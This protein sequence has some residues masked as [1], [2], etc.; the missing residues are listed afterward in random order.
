[1]D[2]VEVLKNV[3]YDSKDNILYFLNKKINFTFLTDSNQQDY[4]NKQVIL[5]P[6]LNQENKLWINIQK[7]MAAI[8]SAKLFEFTINT[9]KRY[10]SKHVK[11]ESEFIVNVTELI[12][13]IFKFLNEGVFKIFQCKQLENCIKIV[14][15][16][17]TYNENERIFNM[18]HLQ[19][20]LLVRVIYSIYK[21]V[22][23]ISFFL[24]NSVCIS[25]THDLSYVCDDFK[26]QNIYIDV[27]CNSCK[28]KNMDAINCKTSIEKKEEISLSILNE[29]E[30]ISGISRDNFEWNLSSRVE[31]LKNCGFHIY[32]DCCLMTFEWNL[33][34][35]ELHHNIAAELSTH[36]MNI[37]VNVNGFSLPFGR[38]HSLF[39]RKIESLNDIWSIAPLPQFIAKYNNSLNIVQT[40]SVI[41]DRAM[42]S[43]SGLSNEQ[44]QLVYF[45]EKDNGL[46][47]Y[48]LV[49][50]I[51]NSKGLIETL[52][53]QRNYDEKIKTLYIINDTS[54]YGSGNLLH[55]QNIIKNCKF[56]FETFQFTLKTEIDNFL[57]TNNTDSNDACDDSPYET[58]NNSNFDD[59]EDESERDIH[60]TYDLKMPIMPYNKLEITNYYYCLKINNYI[61]KLSFNNNEKYKLKIIL[62]VLFDKTKYS[63]CFEKINKD[64]NRTFQDILSELKPFF[65]PQYSDINIDKF[66]IDE[67]GEGEEE[68]QEDGKINFNSNFISKSNEKNSLRVI[69]TNINQKPTT[70]EYAMDFDIW[71][72]NNGEI[73]FKWTDVI[74]NRAKNRLTSKPTDE[75]LRFFISVIDSI[76]NL[77]DNFICGTLLIDCLHCE[78]AQAKKHNKVVLFQHKFIEISKILICDSKKNFSLWCQSTFLKGKNGNYIIKYMSEKGKKKKNEQ[79]FNI[80]KLNIKNISQTQK[81]VQFHGSRHFTI[82]DYCIEF[83]LRNGF[84]STVLFMLINQ[85]RTKFSH[86]KHSSS[87]LDDLFT[88]LHFRYNLNEHAKYILLSYETMY[89]YANLLTMSKNYFNINGI[90]FALLWYLRDR[91]T[92]V[93]LQ[94]YCEKLKQV[95]SVF[96]VDIEFDKYIVS[97][98]CR[99]VYCPILLGD[100]T[101]LFDGTQYIKIDP[102]TYKYFNDAQ[103]FGTINPIKFTLFDYSRRTTRGIYSPVLNILEDNDVTLKSD[104]FQFINK[105]DIDCYKREVYDLCMDIFYKIPHFIEYTKKNIL[106]FCLHG[107]LT[108]L[109]KTTSESI[110]NFKFYAETSVNI[111]DLQ[112]AYN[113][114][115]NDY[116]LTN[117]KETIFRGINDRDTNDEWIRNMSV[118]IVILN[119]IDFYS[120]LQKENIDSILTILFGNQ[121]YG[122]INVKKENIA[123]EKRKNETD[124]HTDYLTLFENKDI[125]SIFH[126]DIAI[127][128]NTTNNITENGSLSILAKIDNYKNS[129]WNKIAEYNSQAKKEL[130]NQH[131]K[132][133]LETINA[134]VE[135]TS[136]LIELQFQNYKLRDGDAFHNKTF[137][138]VL[139]NILNNYT[140]DEIWEK[141]VANY[142]TNLFLNTLENYIFQYALLLTNFFAKRNV[143]KGKIS[144]FYNIFQHS[145]EHR[146]TIYDGS[147]NFIIKY[148]SEPFIANNNIELAAFLRS[149]CE[150]TEINEKIL[151][152]EEK[153][154][155]NFRYI[156]NSEENEDNNVRI[157]FK[158]NEDFFL[159]AIENND[160]IPR[161]V[162]QSRNR[163]CSTNSDGSAYT[164]YTDDDDDNC[165]NYDDN[166]DEDVD[167]SDLNAEC[168]E[169]YDEKNYKFVKSYFVK[170]VSD[171][172][173]KKNI[174]IEKYNENVM[175]DKIYISF[176]FFLY[177]SS[178]DAHVFYEIVKLVVKINFPGQW[179]KQFALFYGESN[180]GKSIFM[181]M[182]D[183]IFRTQDNMIPAS[184][185]STNTEMANAS[186]FSKCLFVY[187]DE[188]N[189]ILAQRVKQNITELVSGRQMFS[190]KFQLQKN[191]AKLFLLN[192]NLPMGLGNDAGVN[193]RIWVNS[194]NHTH[195]S[196]GLCDRLMCGINRFVASNVLSVQIKSRVF[197]SDDSYSEKYS[198]GLYIMVYQF[199]T[200]LFYYKLDTP[201][202]KRVSKITANKRNAF[203]AKLDDL[204]NFHQHFQ[205]DYCGK[206]SE[207]ELDTNIDYYFKY[208]YPNTTIKQINR[209]RLKERLVN[210]LTVSHLTNRGVKIYD[211]KFVPHQAVVQSLGIKRNRKK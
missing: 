31:S 136:N 112:D 32:I 147:C 164:V 86:L 87:F 116:L 84:V 34:L 46:N 178:F 210:E 94:Y 48:P 154:C 36:N 50:N 150:K 190:Q 100:H 197:P 11:N 189:H 20:N 8:D 102:K 89:S 92:A 57:V 77:M 19:Y 133:L 60:F 6:S 27:D 42:I 171:M 172:L 15:I 160:K 52:N 3:K 98:L 159:T 99:N 106:S 182:L 103:F 173:H 66:L 21:F 96:N 151:K 75:Q 139:F 62:D 43:F 26:Y 153:K 70:S 51:N 105:N 2:I 7:Y 78:N 5:T 35:F 208:A 132:I 16:S 101:A 127:D 28:E 170:T 113:C 61:N 115:F 59:E 111:S 141:I 4:N 88:I 179:S 131:D 90:P 110:L 137:E 158:P 206:M 168:F 128:N 71:R 209:D 200:H 176:V 23:C 45:F 83:L 33:I 146:Q 145:Y 55:L 47:I 73:K 130:L 1:M 163:S 157:L 191:K 138:A 203:I 185:L 124:V 129:F 156:F 193:T 165:N 38:N 24:N 104:L 187:V 155:Y 181:Y 58:K 211:R 162:T 135:K 25:I 65:L 192:N 119:T 13:V 161:N 195:T 201:V 148:C 123:A 93:N 67:Y 188:A 97:Y 85:Y 186:Q 76:P 74:I 109:N 80:S 202:D 114:S 198:D 54:L 82:I 107:P 207:I 39:L 12:F 41:K 63:E 10:F 167:C 44:E 125:N 152:R 134:S 196:V 64:K 177:F 53:T 175:I 149:F 194:F 122:H 91:D 142:S 121:K 180:S 117:L 69:G 30:R 108:L 40:N 29:L 174:Y 204:I 22:Q 95:F 126:S 118:W 17:P 49:S 183:S 166:D 56:F 81:I 169:K 144:E 68:E 37:D 14:L 143:Q 205:S 199:L 79:E 120:D 72:Y 140:F 18:N 184:V 9:F